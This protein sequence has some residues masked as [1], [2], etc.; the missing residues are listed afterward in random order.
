MTIRHD[1]LRVRWLGYATA[2][3]DGH[4]TVVYTDPGRYGVLT[5]EWQAP[6]GVDTRHPAGPA[7]DARDGDLVLVTHDHHYDP[8]GVRRVAAPDATLVVYEGVDA[9]RAGRPPSPESLSEA[10]GYDLLRIGADETIE[11]A[12][13]PVRSL[14][15]YNDPDGPYARPDGSVVHPEG[16][17]V[18]YRFEVGGVPVF[19]PGDSD[20]LARHSSLDV[21]LFLAN[22]SGSVCMDRHDAADLA[23]RLDPDL[24]CP[25]HYDTQAFLATESQAFAADVASRGIPVVLDEGWA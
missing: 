4:D 2:R 23:E 5:G 12:G 22:I 11:A 24:V 17:G 19:W 18:G 21:S 7:Y 8:D 14:P 15:A 1:G 25:I 6:K 9:E 16:F 20:V 10:E 13:V 3:I